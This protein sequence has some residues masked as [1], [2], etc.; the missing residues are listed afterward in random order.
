[1][2]KKIQLPFIFFV[3]FLLQSCVEGLLRPIRNPELGV[4]S[5][6]P[7]GGDMAGG[8]NITMITS[9]V[10][11]GAT[12]M[13]GSSACTPVVV[14][15]NQ[16]SCTTLIH[17][18]Q[19]VSITITNP[20][21]DTAVL[22][23]AY[24]YLDV[25]TITS[26]SPT[27]GAVTGGTAVTVNGTNFFQEATI[28]LGT[29]ACNNL[30]VISSTVITCTT[31]ANAAG[32]VDVTITNID[33]QTA[34]SIGA[35]THQPGPTITNVVPASG[36][37][38]G[39]TI[40]NITG[41]N[42]M[43]GATVFFGITSCTVNALTNTSITCTTAANPVGLVDVLVTN[44][45]NQSAT[46]ISGFSYT[47][48]PVIASI[49]PSI[50][51]TTGGTSITITGSGFVAAT[52]VTVGGTAC[53]TVTVNNPS[54]II[55]VTPAGASGGANVVVTNPD[56]QSAT[57]AL[58]FVYTVPPTVAGIVPSNGLAS[59]GTSVTITG[60]GFL[61]NATVDLGGA[62]CTISLI[63]TT[64]IS[65]TTTARA[66]GVVN[67]NV[68]NPDGQ[69]GSL[70]TGYT[71]DPPPTI[72]TVTPIGGPLAGGTVITIDGSGYVFGIT[73]S[74]GGIPCT[75]VNFIN[76]GRIT[77]TTASRLAGTF[78]L[79][80]TNPD[81]QTVTMTSAYTYGE[82]PVISLVEPTMGP[83]AGGSVIT[84]LGRNFVNGATVSMGGNPCTPVV[85][86][87]S[88]QI[89]C[90]TPAGTGGVDL[91][92]TNPDN[93][94][95]IQTLGFLYTLGPTVINVAPLIG[96]DTGGDTVT[97]T[98]TIFFPGLTV[99]LG[100]AACT[101]VI[102]NPT[103][104]T[105]TTGSHVPGVVDVVVT[106]PDNQSATL[107]NAFTYNSAPSILTVTPNGGL[108]VG[109]AAITIDGSNFMAGATVSLGGSPCNTVTFINTNQ[110]TCLTP[111]G[112]LNTIVDV[113][114]T[115]LNTLTGTLLGGYTYRPAPAIA[116]INPIFGPTAGG[117]SITITGTGF[118]SGARVT[119]GGID[120]T[121]NMLTATQI[122]CTAG[123]RNT[124]GTVN[125][126]VINPDTLNA[127]GVSAYTY[128]LPPAISNI[129]PTLWVPPGGGILT[130]VGIDFVAGASVTVG[131][132]SCG[133][134]TN[135][136]TEITC[137]IPARGGT[138][139]VDVVV[140]NPDTQTSTLASSFTYQDTAILNW[141]LGT[142]S[143]NPPNP[144]NYGTSN[145]NITHTF[146]LI[147]NGN[148][149][150]SVINVFRTG[151]DAAAW[152]IGTDNCSGLG[153]EL[154][155]GDT[156]TVQVTFL[157]AFLSPTRS[158]T[159]ILRANAAIGG[160]ADNGIL[161]QT[162]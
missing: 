51:A 26:I 109:G 70:A 99:S 24:T 106:N 147:N 7:I 75:P 124:P 8:T 100:G 131:G 35:Y 72:N 148:R 29:N 77:C 110:L 83:L 47:N 95:D 117:N 36:S 143:P 114:V 125:V 139:T 160:D 69:T 46:S 93:Q 113:V 18:A 78:P 88:S 65:C 68:T 90:T 39:G 23:N 63:N 121:I 158:Y 20:D 154:A 15:A 79:T 13:V 129:T 150:T 34:T 91:V 17:L 86:V 12:V 105:C 67:V 76:A 71:Y 87:N 144:D 162:P 73:A 96:V 27:V 74:L 21:G 126:I 156:C 81:N 145:T 119:L 111:P 57:Q 14:S 11:S 112:T 89:T 31:P 4:Y 94:N 159:A 115:N 84:I 52:T 66:G 25:P 40:V 10:E 32:T 49:I 128:N 1:M 59:G 97:I 58:G 61:P 55:C 5:V 16:V 157:A 120:C 149:T 130:V 30:T 3:V 102:T 152:G 19:N 50:G 54:E 138:G 9:S 44:P 134:L 62:S 142:I 48:P 116:N 6:S 122:D 141:V 107:A 146:T 151:A 136:L 133:I 28:F 22:N 127:T 123:V 82:G 33:G 80:L 42:F 2:K 60:T 137:T 140:T 118:L 56:T 103:Q 41:I 135:T 153:N 155:P 43:P 104:I 45:D 101:P 37:P 53:T 85:V 98:G 161:G 132:N 38:F 64:Q 108:P 92:V